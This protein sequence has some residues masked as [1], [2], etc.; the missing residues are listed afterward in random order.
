MTQLWFYAFLLSPLLL[1]PSVERLALS[2]LWGSVMYLGLWAAWELYL[3]TQHPELWLRA[4][5]FLIIP[6]QIAALVYAWRRR[7]HLRAP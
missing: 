3:R 4:D 1:F 5:L 2:P 7:K 6:A